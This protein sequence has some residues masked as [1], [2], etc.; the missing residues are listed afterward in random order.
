MIILY[1]NVSLNKIIKKNL[2]INVFLHIIIISVERYTIVYRKVSIMFSFIL[3]CRS[4][5]IK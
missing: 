2:I 4:M 1:Y 3:K 5:L